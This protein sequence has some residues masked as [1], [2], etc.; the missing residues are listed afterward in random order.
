MTRHY[1]ARHFLLPRTQIIM[2][3]YRLAKGWVNVRRAKN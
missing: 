2:R 3:A 1:Q